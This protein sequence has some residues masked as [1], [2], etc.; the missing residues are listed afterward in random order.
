MSE[1]IRFL[2][3]KPTHFKVD[4]VINPWMEGNLHQSAYETAQQ[5]W[6]QLHQCILEHAGVD[7]IEPVQGWPD[8]VF[9]ANAGLVMGRKAVVSR[10]YYPERR[11][12]EPYFKQWFAE[13][14]FELYELPDELPFEGAG[15]AL[16]DRAQPRLWAAYGFRSL[17]ASHR[18]LSEWL[19][20]EVVSLRLIDQRFYHLD[21]C[22]CP[23]PEGYTL[24][25]PPAFD[26]EAQATIEALIPADKRLVV[27]EADAENFACNAV[28]IGRRVI[29]H[30][31][32]D[33][34]KGQLAQAG[35][36]VAETPL[37]EFLKAGGAAK[38]L[39]LRTNEPLL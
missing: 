14:G 32:S 3:C 27:S 4:Y 39:T 2:M 38:C 34:L 31:A 26:D 35:F 17:K 8:M 30:Q 1:P 18:R 36:Q 25:F 15:D 20:V 37:T 24:Y 6:H 33:A 10:F 13:K 11:G 22:F 19:D 12:E 21:T 5:Q 9:T 28:N 29:M 7:L 23:L 16:F